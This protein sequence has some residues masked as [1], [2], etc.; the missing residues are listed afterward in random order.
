MNKTINPYS[1]T[2]GQM[3]FHK[4]SGRV[5]SVLHVAEVSTNNR[6]HAYDVVYRRL[7]N[8]ITTYTRVISEFCDGRFQL[9]NPDHIERLVQTDM[10]DAQ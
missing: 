6:G 8:R 9:I 2:P 5:Y 3:Y 7:G 10:K 4:K 1:V